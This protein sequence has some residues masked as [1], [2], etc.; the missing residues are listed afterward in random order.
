MLVDQPFGAS[1]LYSADSQWL[2]G[3]AIT[4]SSTANTGLLRYRF[5][6]NVY[7]HAG[8]VYQNLKADVT[9]GG[10]A[11]GPL[12]VYNAV[13]AGMRIQFSFSY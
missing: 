10:A 7:V 3:T 2:S 6:E 12:N 4:D 8:L 9:L 5:S 1:V 11:Y 13:S